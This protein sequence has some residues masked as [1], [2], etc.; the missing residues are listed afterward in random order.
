MNMWLTIKE[1]LLKRYG[2]S[3]FQVFNNV[4][5]NGLEIDGEYPDG[6]GIFPLDYLRILLVHDDKKVRL[7]CKFTWQSSLEIEH[8]QA[9][10]Q[11]KA[12][13]VI[14]LP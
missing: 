4:T 12:S 7:L 8:D 5:L 3:L 2:S 1:L 10:L 14:L 11:Y 9:H 13:N 6:E